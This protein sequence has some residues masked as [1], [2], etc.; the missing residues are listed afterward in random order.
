[1]GTWTKVKWTQAGQIAE[2]IG[3]PGIGE[4]EASPETGYR[5]LRDQ[6]DLDTAVRYLAHALPRVEAIA[7]AAQLLDERS[8]TSKLLATERQSLDRTIRWLE[9]PTDEY[10]RAAFEAAG[11]APEDSPERLLACA[12]FMSGGSISEPDL[13]AVQPQQHVCGQLAAAA[14]L[15]AAYRSPEADTALAAACDLGDRIAS[16]GAKAPVRQ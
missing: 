14:V 9:Q 2:L 7:W 13:P 16:E 12:V 11:Q 4:S 10:R 1:M 6:G 3:R 15:T 5:Q 8:R